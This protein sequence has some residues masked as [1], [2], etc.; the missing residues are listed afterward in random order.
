MS[1]PN[2]RTSSS[3]SS[4]VS[5]ASMMLVTALQQT[6][7]DTPPSQQS[8]SLDFDHLDS[9][10]TPPSE[11]SPP[12]SVGDFFHNFMPMQTLSPNHSA[13]VTSNGTVQY[14]ELSGGHEQTLS[15]TP[16]HQISIVS[17]DNGTP[18]ISLSPPSSTS[19]QSLGAVLGNNRQ[20]VN[21]D[22]HSS[23]NALCMLYS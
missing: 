18:S 7:L 5:S 8:D 17:F 21:V 14:A 12:L 2:S 15:A 13:N 23:G 19:S 11:P 3:P 22:S 9:M 4:P 10:W 20:R 6:V 1:S 16:L